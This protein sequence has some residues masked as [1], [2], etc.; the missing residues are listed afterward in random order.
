MAKGITAQEMDAITASGF[1]P[2]LGTTTNSSNSYSVT[3]NTPIS[4]NQKFTIKFNVASSTAPTLKINNDTALPIK[5]ANG[6]NAKLY[7]SVYTL[8]RDGSA[9][10]LQGEGGEYGTAQAEHVLSPYTI[11]T[12]DGVV[13]GTYEPPSFVSGFLKLYYSNSFSW[14][15]SQ[16]TLTEPLNVVIPA[17]TRLITLQGEFEYE[18]ILSSSDSY[19]NS[20][21]LRLRDAAGRTNGIAGVSQ[22]GSNIYTSTGNQVDLTGSSLDRTRPMTLEFAFEPSSS[23]SRPYDRFRARLSS[24]IHYSS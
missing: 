6:N 22:Q 17:H 16:P 15:A 24:N 14:S 11:G 23:Q 21:S 2:H 9:F 19:Y 4:T 10:I 8:F 3:S 5:K 1:V 12:E 18:S 7:A 20:F 13:V